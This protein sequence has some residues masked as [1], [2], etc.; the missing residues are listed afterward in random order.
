MQIQQN[1]T[2]LVDRLLR[3]SAWKWDGLILQCSRPHTWLSGD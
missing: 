3:N 2:T 1:K